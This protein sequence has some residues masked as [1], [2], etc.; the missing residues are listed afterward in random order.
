[1]PAKYITIQAKDMIEFLEARAFQRIQL[2]GTQEIVFARSQKL[3]QHDD[4]GQLMWQL[5]VSIRVYTGIHLSGQQRDKG[6]DAIRVSVWYKYDNEPRM[7]G[8]DKRVHRVE[9]WREN[10]DERIHNWMRCIEPFCPLCTAP[11]LLHKP[12]AGGKFF[13]AFY[14]CIRYSKT[15]PSCGGTRP[16]EEK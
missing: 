16:Y 14:G 1:M 10:L 4:A 3:L 9:G 12:K 7:L 13:H 11:M 2:P 5:P 15:G 6:K 8:G